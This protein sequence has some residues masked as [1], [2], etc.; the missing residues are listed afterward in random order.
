MTLSVFTDM[1][2][3]DVTGVQRLFP[4]KRDNNAIALERLLVSVLRGVSE[5]ASPDAGADSVDER[6]ALGR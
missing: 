4:L 3:S 5:A 2:E 6:R 1:R